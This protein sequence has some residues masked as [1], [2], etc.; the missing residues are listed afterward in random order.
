MYDGSMFVC[1]TRMFVCMTR[2]FTSNSEVYLRC[3]SM[4][5]GHV[6]RVCA[7]HHF[8][9]QCSQVWDLGQSRMAFSSGIGS[10]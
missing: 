9:A 1:M 5:S 6:S 3:C 4:E 2:M 10:G 7:P 8:T